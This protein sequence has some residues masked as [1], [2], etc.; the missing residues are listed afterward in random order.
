MQHPGVL[1]SGGQ[2]NFV[3]REVKAKRDP[4]YSEYQKAVASQYAALD[5][6]LQGHR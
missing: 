3:K 5:Y 6:K 2:L 4:I 1:V